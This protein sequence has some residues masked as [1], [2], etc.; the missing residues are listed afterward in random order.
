MNRLHTATAL[1]AG[2][3][4][5]GATLTTPPA[6]AERP[7]AP[8]RAAGR[9]S[10]D[11]AFAK[12]LDKIGQISPAEFARRYS[13][14]HSYLEKLSWDPAT[15]KFYDQFNKPGSIHDFRLNKTSGS[16]RHPRLPAQ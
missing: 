16:I 12:Q 15:G 11:A 4:V 2:L 13:G 6:R 9:F 10:P 8:Q 1:L 5:L 7:K 14:K 3:A